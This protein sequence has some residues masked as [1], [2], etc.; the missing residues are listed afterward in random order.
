MTDQKCP[1]CGCDIEDDAFE[2]EGAVYCCEPCAVSCECACGCIEESK[3]AKAG[4]RAP[5]TGRRR[6]S[7]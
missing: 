5:Q 4:V 3:P 2:K 6:G 1:Q 7:K